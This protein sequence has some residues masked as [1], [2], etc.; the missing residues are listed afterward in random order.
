MRDGCGRTKDEDSLLL[1]TKELHREETYFKPQHSFSVHIYTDVRKE[2]E[3]DKKGVASTLRLSIFT[4]WGGGGKAEKSR[5][6]QLQEALT[7]TKASN[8]VNFL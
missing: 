8:S 1:G 5:R 4:G 7:L 3:K 6:N 2:R